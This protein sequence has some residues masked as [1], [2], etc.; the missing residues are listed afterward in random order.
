MPL[1]LVGSIRLGWMASAAGGRGALPI[2]DL[3]AVRQIPEELRYP[4]LRDLRG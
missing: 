3:G 2:A 4:R 1:Y